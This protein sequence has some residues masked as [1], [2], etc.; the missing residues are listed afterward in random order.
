[1]FMRSNGKLSR[2]GFVV[3]A[4]AGWLGADVRHLQG[5]IPNGGVGY[6]FELQPRSNVRIDIG[7]GRHST[8]VYFNFTEAY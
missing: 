1:M 5:I 8:G 7:V 2:H 6:R 4:G 3:W